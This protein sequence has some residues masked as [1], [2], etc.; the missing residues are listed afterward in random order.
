[1]DLQAPRVV[2]GMLILGPVWLWPVS[3]TSLER[4]YY[5]PPAHFAA[6]EPDRVV[7]LQFNLSH[8]L[9]RQ[10]PFY[11]SYT[12]RGFWD[13]SGRTKS[14]PF[15]DINHHPELQWIFSPR[16]I[17][18]FEHASNGVDN[19]PSGPEQRANQSRSVN[20]FYW[21]SFWKVPGL[22]KLWFAPRVDAPIVTKNSTRIHDYIGYASSILEWR[23]DGHVTGYLR[24]SRGAKGHQ[25]IAQA[26]LDP[27]GL[28][29]SRHPGNTR[30]FVEY[31][32]GYGDYLVDFDKKRDVMRVGLRLLQ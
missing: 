32:N 26:T 13:R 20:R 27:L 8:Q 22:S 19:E 17:F 16:H 14:N 15:I 12:M 23:E 9:I 4:S 31:F 3:A 28:L 11:F 21:Q 5:E 25:F 30:L 7:K 24:Y 18:S 29:D 2:L 6:V 10:L 1:M